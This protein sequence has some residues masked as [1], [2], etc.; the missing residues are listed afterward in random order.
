MPEEHLRKAGV[1]AVDLVGDDMEIIEA[2]APA[3]LLGEEAEVPRRA[4]RPVAAMVAGVDDIARAG[5]RFGEPRVASAVLGEP[6]RDLERRLRLALRRPAAH[7]NGASLV[8]NA[9]CVRLQTFPPPLLF[10]HKPATAA[11]AMDSRP[12]ARKTDA[13]PEQAMSQK[14]AKWR[15]QRSYKL[16]LS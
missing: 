14:V 16:H 11:R 13:S 6:M 15:G 1:T 9:Q 12:G 4:G 2:G 3:I 5:Q 7:E 8:G 10:T